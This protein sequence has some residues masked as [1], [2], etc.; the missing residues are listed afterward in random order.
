MLGFPVF[1]KECQPGF[2][3]SLPLLF[4]VR[5]RRV[6]S[7]G[8]PM[9]F[10]PS[11]FKPACDFDVVPALCPTN[12]PNVRGS[13]GSWLNAASERNESA[14]VVRILCTHVYSWHCMVSYV[15]PTRLRRPIQLIP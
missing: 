2:A 12:S 13:S 10:E 1:H 9:L 14:I 3:K 7:G 4:H 15:L 8:L 6:K 5:Q 11:L